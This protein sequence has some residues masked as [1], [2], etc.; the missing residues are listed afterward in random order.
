MPTAPRLER[1]SPRPVGGRYAATAPRLERQRP[2]QSEWLWGVISALKRGDPLAPVTVVGP[3]V[4]ANLSLRQELAA[5]GFANVRF[6]ILSRVAEL[7]GAPRLVAAHPDISPLK[8]AIETTAIR[9]A[10]EA[11]AHSRLSDFADNSGAIRSLR[12]TFRDLRGAADG[13][14]DAISSGALGRDVVSIYRAFLERT[15]QDFYDAESLA[16]AAA[17]AV[18]EGTAAGLDDL[19]FVVFYHVSDLSAGETRLVRALSSAGMC[20]VALGLTGDA[21]ADAHTRTLARRLSPS[22][23]TDDDQPDERDGGSDTPSPSVPKS[24]E[25]THLLIAPTPREEIR[26]VIR[27]IARRAE[28]GTPFH[29]IAILY[30][31]PSPYSSLIREELELAKLPVAGPDTTPLYQTAVGRALIGLMNLAGGDFSRDDVMSWL[32]GCPVRPP[33]TPA[34][35][36]VPSYWDAISKKAGV[37]RGIEQW[38][39]RLS[40]HAENMERQADG[41]EGEVSAA[42][43]SGMRA[44]ANAA[45]DLADFVNTLA[46]DLK[47]PPNGSAW[48]AFRKWAADTFENFLASRS[49]IPDSE[50]VALDNITSRMEDLETA[51]AV[52]PSPTF[53]S[54]RQ[55]LNEA[56]SSSVGRLGP[57]GEGVFVA[58]LATAAAL[59]FDIAYFVGMIEGAAPPA[60]RENPLMPDRARTAAGGADAGLPLL[61]ERRARERRQFLSAMATAPR[62]TLSYPVA[63]PVGGREN[64]PSRWLLEQATALEGER[65]AATA[66]TSLSDRRWL[67]VITSPSTALQTVAESAPADVHDYDVERIWR[68]TQS[69]RQARY[70]PIAESGSLAAAL[71]LG[72]MRNSAQLTEWDGNLTS[73]PEALRPMHRPRHSASSLELWA[74]C[75]FSYFLSYGLRIRAL[76][77]P[78]DEYSI[79]PIERGSLVHTVL[80]EFIGAAM[81]TRDIPPPPQAWSESQRGELRRIALRRFEDLE[82]KGALGK[83]MLWEIDREEILADFDA[84]LEWDSSIRERF[85]VTPHLVEA[86]FGMDGDT[87]DVELLLN[88]A[89]AIHFRGMADRIDTSEDRSR[90]L[91]IDYKTGGSTYYDVLDKDPLD[92]GRKLQLAIYSLAARSLLG[93]NVSVRAAYGFV[94]GRGGFQI[95]PKEP[96]DYG[97]DEMLGRFRKATSAIVNGIHEGVF[98]A[99]PGN[100]GYGGYDNCR[101]CD[102]DSICPSR[103]DVMWRRKRSDKTAAAYVSLFEEE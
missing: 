41:D 20:A 101:F 9:A 88:A 21:D 80:E 51:Q 42:L 97:S 82:S 17:E 52:D 25:N 85:R 19:G 93:E 47:P 68:W 27:Q 28:S 15:R 70:H 38:Q 86:K 37:V 10:L 44:E 45:R 53:E 3:S 39:R 89:D 64:Y 76:D 12:T 95:R 23:S 77:D 4:Y 60:L 74:K 50:I 72:R 18:N 13:A 11:N 35:R 90:A 102:F 100:Q 66:L 7:L 59:S 36:F 79:T 75:P 73:A 26:W 91:V 69:G 2:Q 31:K 55:A 65:V 8:P 83:P 24:A 49:H 43:A 94:S 54:F 98:P 62:R 63:D 84:F 103:R 58:Q 48:A 57:T 87:P 29:R 61:S 99:N 67:T 78:E 6:V 71:D 32:T 92:S 16:R 22:P 14:L 34:S 40:A 46:D 1:Q 30:R 56:L 81:E 96:L 5:H 33:G